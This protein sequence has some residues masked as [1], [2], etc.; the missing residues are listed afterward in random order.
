MIFLK[1]IL[2]LNI[3]LVM[4]SILCAKVQLHA[5]PHFEKC[6][7]EISAIYCTD[8]KGNFCLRIILLITDGCDS[9]LLLYANCD[10]T[11]NSNE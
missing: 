9:F 5:Y 6:L 3:Y 10:L 1:T 2:F 11:P 7:G 8:G 4:N